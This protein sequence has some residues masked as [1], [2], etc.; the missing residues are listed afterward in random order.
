MLEPK[1]YGVANT[2]PAQQT[3]GVLKTLT[4]S[5]VRAQQAMDYANLLYPEVEK[6]DPWEAA[7]RFFS[8]MGKAASQP[9]STA[10]SAAVSSMDAP[11]DYLNAKKKEKTE[12]DRARLQTALQIAPSLKPK[13]R[14]G[15]KTP[16][17]YMISMPIIGADGQPTGEYEAQIRNFLTPEQFAKLQ[18][19]GAR[20]ESVPKTTSATFKRTV[21]RP[22]GS[23]RVVYSQTEFDSA[24]APVSD[25]NPNGGWST[26]QPVSTSNQ[27]S[28]L[29]DYTFSSPEGLAKFKAAYPDITLS[30][31]QEAGIV[32]ISL[33]NRVSNDPN[34]L[35][36]FIKY[37]DPASNQSSVLTD[38][39]FSSPEGLAKFKAAYPDITLSAEQE[40]GIV[41]ISLPNRVSNDPNLLGVFIKYKAP[42]GGNSQYERLLYSVNDIGTRIAAFNADNTLPEV[43]Q[44]DIN[45]YAANYQRL[46]AGGKYTEIVNGQEVTRF[47][48]GIDLSGTT[49][50]P[51]PEGLDLDAIIEER[52]QK[53]DQN[54]NTSAT[55]GSRMLYNEGVLR[56]VLAEGYVLSLEDIA[57]IRVMQRLGLGNIGVN[58]QAQQFHVAAQNWVAAQLRNESGAAIAPSEYADALLQ[59]FPKVGD[60]AETIKQKQALREEATKG[61]INSAG[62][63]FKVVYPNGQQYLTYT[64]DGETYDILNPQGYANELISKTELGQNLFF[65]DTIRSKLTPDLR[66]MLANPNAANLYTKQMIGMISEELASRGTE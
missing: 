42:G 21:H 27:S 35:G 41:P 29:T 28:A 37:K 18:K 1:K 57:Q 43:S 64:S 4:G 52:S 19:Q 45:E 23:T 16:S 49:N 58:P 15:Y 8:D 2:D 39:T 7:F 63:A 56:N 25:A 40:A 12:T 34:L 36:A 14:G 59:Y 60:S 13:G 31:E 17:E 22:D 20:F 51:V 62:D 54:Q 24:T 9:G 3:M 5:G 55:F 46:I 33:P 32:P 44:K 48:A 10:L 47:R 38:Y 11:L 50:L 65:R 61:M 30:A 6:V 26:T 53:F 66:R